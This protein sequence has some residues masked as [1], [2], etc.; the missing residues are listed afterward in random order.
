MLLI[1]GHWSLILQ[2]EKTSLL[3]LQR[4]PTLNLTGS[5]V[6]ALWVEGT[7]CILV[8][9]NNTV[10]LATLIYAMCLD[11]IVMVLTAYKLLDARSINPSIG[12]SKIANLIFKDGL[13][14]FFIAYVD[15]SL[16]KFSQLT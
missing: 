7:G 3:S 1:L 8:S 12:E 15:F 10:L 16:L 11:L 4:L 5:L 9:T 14:F 6:S 2:G 13:I